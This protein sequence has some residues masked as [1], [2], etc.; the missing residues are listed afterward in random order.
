VEFGVQPVHL[1]LLRLA[2]RD[3]GVGDHVANAAPGAVPHCRGCDGDGDQRA[4][5]AQA[6]S[7]KVVDRL[8]AQHALEELLGLG[9]LVRRRHREASAAQHLLGRPAEDAL[10]RRVPEPDAGV[11]PEFDE[12]ER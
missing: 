4:V 6:N 3:V 10:S 7:V 12:R 9:A 8:T 2:L 11:Q 1:R 5:L